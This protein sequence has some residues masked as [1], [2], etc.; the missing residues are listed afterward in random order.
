MDIDVELDA[1]GLSCPMPI[2]KLSK[3]VKS[4]EVGQV[5]KMISS[6]PGSEEDVPKWVKRSKNELLESNK[7]SGSYIF[8]IKKLK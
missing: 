6:D 5:I 1:T 8:V 4:M 7:E 2:M 3:S